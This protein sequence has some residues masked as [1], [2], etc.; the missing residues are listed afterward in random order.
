M[1]DPDIPNKG[2]FI[3]KTTFINY[4][5]GRGGGA[6]A[7]YV[8]VPKVSAGTCRAGLLLLLDVGAAT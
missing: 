1:Y 3:S 5:A 7:F 4:I 2:L 6:V 8:A